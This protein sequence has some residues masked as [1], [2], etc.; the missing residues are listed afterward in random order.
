MDDTGLNIGHDSAARALNLKTGT[1]DRLTIL[2]GG[3]VGIGTTSP[4]QKL[5][6]KAGTDVN[7]QVGAVSGELQLKS[8]ND[9]DSA[10]IPMILRA[11]EFNIL[12]GNV[13]IGTTSPSYKLDVVGATNT[14]GLYSRGANLGFE[15]QIAALGTQGAYQAGYYLGATNTVYAARIGM[16][17][18]SGDVY[19]GI[20]NTGSLSTVT[21]FK[22]NGNVGI[23]TTNPS[24]NLDVYG[25][26]RF[27]NGIVTNTATPVKMIVSGGSLND[28]TELRTG[29]GEF[30][31]YSGR[32]NATHQ[33]FVFATGDNYT[34]GAVRMVI[35]GSGNVGIGTTS[36]AQKLEVSGNQRITGGFLE[37]FG[38][39]TYPQISR[40][41]VSGGLIINT[42]G[43]VSSSVPLLSVRNNSGN[44]F[45]TVLGNS[46][47]GIN[48]TSP[49][50]KLQV[51]EYT[52]A[53]QGAQQVSGQLSVFANSGSESLYLGVKNAA[54]PNRGWA[55]NT[56]TSGVNS[57]LQI[58]EHGLTGVRM[59]IASGG[60]VGIGTTTP[61]S[62]LQVQGSGT[63]SATTAFRVENANASS[64]MVVLDNGNVGIGTSS[65]SNSLTVRT[66]VND[67]GILLESSTGNP[68]FLVRKDGTS[69]N[70]A[71]LF[72]YGSGAIR[73]AIRSIT[74]FSYFNGGNFGFGTPTDVGYRLTISG[75]STSGSLNVDNILYVS[76]S[77][78]GIGI[79]G[80]LS[81]LA[82]YKSG[83]TVLDIQGSQGQL[84]SVVDALSGSLMSVNDV[85]GLPILE[86]FS[87]DRV[88]MGTY[89]APALT[90]SGS[91][92]TVA[93]ASAA[94]SGTV[95]EGTFRFATVGGAY[96]IYAYI[97]GAWRSGSLS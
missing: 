59:T 50:G 93:T 4:L 61:T 14:A 46:N 49:L 90:V 75:S 79:S 42:S 29:N 63:T 92:V 60:N 81:K 51:D 56:V 58:K 62:R 78:V 70:T 17:V 77:N 72:Q 27:T 45:I 53:A 39:V 43:V 7:L 73:L 47:V 64:S 16:N 85:S 5:H 1:V 67:D 55:L 84:F 54:Y 8:T 87:D 86:V 89:G 68:L 3:N 66:G 15:S 25:Q 30:R 91:A 2:G 32:F 41:G 94:P 19:L 82:V 48:T 10:Y 31:I 6:L 11:S 21:Y 35:T 33:S 13:G 28:S 9:A 37:F 97:G 69:N 83:S 88:V 71:E 12:N 38:G 24:Y 65:P 18:S 96:Y 74:N 22:A 80:S 52:V 23:G 44:D 34:S 95:P 26:A 36:P 20:G 40:S 76:G 57:N